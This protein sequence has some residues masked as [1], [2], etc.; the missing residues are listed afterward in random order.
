MKEADK[1]EYTKGGEELSCEQ[2]DIAEEQWAMRVALLLNP[3]PFY[4]DLP[5]II[6]F[7]EKAW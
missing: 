3:C 2:A 6:N 4:I 7:D 5:S 1:K